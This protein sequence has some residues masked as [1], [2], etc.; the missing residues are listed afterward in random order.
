MI[1]LFVY[2]VSQENLDEDPIM[3]MVAAQFQKIILSRTYT[4]G[5][6]G[7]GALI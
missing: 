5:L 2:F 4:V 6:L 7:A 1:S 3:F